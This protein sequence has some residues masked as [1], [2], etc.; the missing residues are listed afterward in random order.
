MTVKTRA[1]PLPLAETAAPA[2]PGEVQALVAEAHAAG[3]PVYPIGGGLALD[4]GLP[5]RREGLGIVL[6]GLARVIDYPARDLTVTVEAGITLE[7]L[8]RTLAAEGQWLPLEAHQPETATL[9]GLA[10]VNF[11]GPRRYACG[12]LRDYVIGITAVDG[13]GEPYSGGGRVVKNVAGY[14]FCKLL[15]GSLGTLGI[16]TQLTL[17]L[18]PLPES[19]AMLLCEPADWD[20]AERLLEQLVHFPAVPASIDLVCGPAWAGAGELEPSHAQALLLAVGLHGSQEEV[21]WQVD[22]LGS[23]WQA[24][25]VERFRSLDQGGALGAWEQLTG[26]GCEGQAALVLKLNVLP[27]R[28]TAMMAMLRDMDPDCSMAAR[29]GSGIVLARFERF[30]P[31][32]VSRL[33]IG[34]IR[35]AA[36]AAKGSCVVWSCAAGLEV[37][38]QAVFGPDPGDRA[39]MRAVKSQ[40]DPAGILNPGRFVYGTA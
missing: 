28:V 7:A 5:P 29:A 3:T 21:V 4:F 13:R 34:K 19:C 40:F 20:Q 25:G 10:A 6:T 26:F 39:L 12:T 8:Q 27:S 35:P 14:D 38:H 15:V 32:D 30:Q 16:I 36:I 23:Q 33:L 18:R 1:L 37:T 22:E 24:A 17:K 9:G 2:E 11:S 31:A